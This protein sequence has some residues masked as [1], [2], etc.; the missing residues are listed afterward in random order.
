MIPAAQTE[1]RGNADANRHPVGFAIDA[2]RERVLPLFHTDN[3]SAANARAAKYGESS[4]SGACR[5][6]CAASSAALPRAVVT[7]SPSCPNANHNQV[8]RGCAPNSG[9]PSAEAAR[10]P[11]QQRMM[12]SCASVGKK[13]CARMSIAASSGISNDESTESNWREEP[14]SHCPVGRAC[15]LNATEA[16]SLACALAP[17][18]SSTN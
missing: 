11:V 2:Q 8:C 13:C 16:P 4:I 7:P 15:T 12:F 17:Y 1:R 5:P 3:S 6:I 10:S 14:I 9:N 18:P